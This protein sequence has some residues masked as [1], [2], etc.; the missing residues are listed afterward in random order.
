MNSWRVILH[1]ESPGQT[2]CTRFDVSG[3]VRPVLISVIAC[4]TTAVAE[5]QATHSRIAQ[6]LLAIGAKSVNC[7]TSRGLG[8]MAWAE[9]SCRHVLALI[10]GQGPLNPSFEQLANNWINSG[11]DVLIIPAL[12]PQLPRNQVFSPPNIFTTL[13]KC[14]VAAWQ[15]NP[16]RLCEALLSAGCLEERP[17]VFISYRR[18]EA[19][20]SADDLHDALTHIGYRVFLDRFE[21]SQGRLFPQ[22]LAENMSNKDLVVLLETD[23]VLQS[24]WTL[25]EAAF[26]RR[27]RIGPVAINFQTA[28]H[29]PRMRWRHHLNCSAATRLSQTDRD[30][31]VEFVKGQ[32][33]RA[34]VMRR[35][36]FE[37]LIRR[38]AQSK[39][40]DA[41]LVSRGA[42]EVLDNHGTPKG[43]ALVSAAPGQLR[44]FYRLCGNSAPLILA[45]EHQHL[46]PIESEAFQWLAR[47]LNVITVGS[48]SIYQEVRNLL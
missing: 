4:D 7:G 44:H 3:V 6:R 41:V 11:N 33:V 22:E 20:A 38:A 29:V 30:S 27:Y 42:M 26:A 14:T 10:I 31:A 25:W 43:A 34:G 39:Q 48:G 15:G 37:T 13:S 8:C 21:G 36:Y 46:P 47:H 40:G 2:S 35:A 24:K 9:Q 16:D 12:L 17:G 1:L 23:S 45:G 28:P 32:V 18:D 19:T 5:A